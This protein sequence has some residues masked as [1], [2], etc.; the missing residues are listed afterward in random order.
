MGGMANSLSDIVDLDTLKHEQAG[1]PA[2]AW[3]MIGLGAGLLMVVVVYGTC[4]VDPDC[5]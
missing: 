1:L 3:P 4:F 5:N 2:W